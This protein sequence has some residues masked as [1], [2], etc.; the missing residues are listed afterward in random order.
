MKHKC[1]Y[2]LLILTS[3]C[4]NA[5][6][7]SPQPP[8][9]S[10]WRNLYIGGNIGSVW[11]NAR[12]KLKIANDSADSYFLPA[13]VSGISSSG[14]LNMSKAQLA[15]GAQIGYNLLIK[16]RLLLGLELSYDY[17]DFDKIKGNTF[18]YTTSN[19]PYYLTT[20]ASI[21]QMGTLRPRIG[22]SFNRFMPFITGGVA[23][24]KF[25]FNQTFS[26]PPFSLVTTRFN[27][28]KYGWSLGTGIEYACFKNI[29]L[30]MDYLYTNFGS[31]STASNLVG[32]GIATGFSNILKNKTSNVIVQNLLFG[33]NYH[34]G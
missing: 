28:I 7:I 26:E 17:F 13:N 3:Q 20:T 29:S 10:Q 30:K 22:F 6:T 23:A 8:V 15:G 34:F 12:S 21:K 14:S 11:G 18:Y 31:T 33:I 2:I 4:S 5:G 27:K 25:N 1:L 19:T 16:S 32:T 24:T 9:Y